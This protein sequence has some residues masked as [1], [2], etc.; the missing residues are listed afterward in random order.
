[1]TI[2]FGYFPTFLYIALLLK[3]TNTVKNGHD[4]RALLK[5]HFDEI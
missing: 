5:G 2:K 1:M 3:E 4:H